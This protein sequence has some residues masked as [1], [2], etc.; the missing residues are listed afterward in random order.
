MPSGLG[1]CSLL[2]NMTLDYTGMAFNLKQIEKGAALRPRLWPFRRDVLRVAQHHCRRSGTIKSS[3][4]CVA[5]S[6]KAARGRCTDTGEYCPMP[7]PNLRCR[8]RLALEDLRRFRGLFDRTFPNRAT[9]QSG[10][11]PPQFSPGHVCDSWCQFGANPR[12]LCRFGRLCRLV[13]HL[14][15]IIQAID[16]SW[17]GR[18]HRFDPGQVHQQTPETEPLPHPVLF[19][20]E[21]QRCRRY[22]LLIGSILWTT[23]AFASRFC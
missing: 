17:H 22:F 21:G 12:R 4:I 11:V 5:S 2:R 8:I 19:F 16:T 23:I 15:S 7:L 3:T 18:G 10:A 13:S 9:W 1:H 14:F 20:S 6:R